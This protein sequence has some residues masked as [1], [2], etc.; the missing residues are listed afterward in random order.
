MPFEFS[1]SSQLDST[2]CLRSP[3]QASAIMPI[4]QSGLSK[5]ENP[6]SFDDG[7]GV[8]FALAGLDAEE[9]NDT[10][11]LLDKAS[12]RRVRVQ[13][14][15]TG[16]PR[17]RTDE[18]DGSRNNLLHDR[19]A[20]KGLN[21]EVE[22]IVARERVVEL[23]DVNELSL[24]PS[25]LDELVDGVTVLVDLREVLRTRERNAELERVLAGV[26]VALA[27]GLRCRHDD[28]EVTDD[29]VEVL[30]FPLG[31]GNARLK[32][33][34]R[35]LHIVRKVGVVK[36]TV[37]LVAT[38]VVSEERNRILVQLERERESRTVGLV[39]RSLLTD[40]SQPLLF[41]FTREDALGEADDGAVL[42]V[43]VVASERGLSMVAIRTN[44]ASEFADTEDNAFLEPLTNGGA[45]KELVSLR[46]LGHN[47][48]ET[49]HP[50]LEELHRDLVGG[51]GHTSVRHGIHDHLEV[52]IRLHADTDTVKG[53]YGA[54]HA[55]GGVERETTAL[56]L[57]LE[58]I[59]V[60]PNGRSKHFILSFL[61]SDCLNLV[62]D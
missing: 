25:L 28:C 59:V 30:V 33:D 27:L 47:C 51:R 49:V 20:V 41:Q 31:R 42:V 60:F 7:F 10:K 52:H 26:E 53:L 4:L 2:V 29:L 8:V 44:R 46:S 16:S 11:R 57:C 3:T 36:N 1:F 48:D 21:L 35:D 56:L 38:K 40:S 55:L 9:A 13:L 37:G 19:V 24:R 23:G 12:S 5:T 15:Q 34:L 6:P 17:N 43:P 54:G 58:G 62:G 61:F 22:H 18:T 14:V 39:G 45:S 32:S 50:V